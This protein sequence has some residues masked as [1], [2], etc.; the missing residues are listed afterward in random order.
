[1][2]LSFDEAPAEDVLLES[3]MDAIVCNRLRAKVLLG[4]DRREIDLREQHVRS[5]S[6]AREI[7]HTE[8]DERFS[9]DGSLLSSVCVSH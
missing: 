7:F 5:P 9:R 1:M 4:E 6:F 3:T 2:T 8:S